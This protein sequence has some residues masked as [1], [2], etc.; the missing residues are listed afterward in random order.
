MY[1]RIYYSRHRPTEEPDCALEM[2]L[3]GN[4]FCI[5]RCHVLLLDHALVSTMWE[6]SCIALYLVKE[7]LGFVTL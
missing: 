6:I 7:K 5:M 1:V 3:K 4:S 2:F